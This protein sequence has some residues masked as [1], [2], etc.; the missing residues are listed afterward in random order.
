MR[1]V[2]TCR[3][4]A[5]TTS[6]A[7]LFVIRQVE[8]ADGPIE[9]RLVFQAWLRVYGVYAMFRI[10]YIVRAPTDPLCE[11]GRQSFLANLFAAVTV[12]LVSETVLNPSTGN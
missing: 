11:E 12:G 8:V 4:R 3:R 10:V 5:P 2:E 9:W 1:T 7:H 6:S